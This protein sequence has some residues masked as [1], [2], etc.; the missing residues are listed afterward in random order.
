[1]KYLKLQYCMIIKKEAYIASHQ[2]GY[3]Y[4][5]CNRINVDKAQ[6]E[7]LIWTCFFI[8]KYFRKT[9]SFFQAVI[10]VLKESFRCENGCTKLIRKQLLH[11]E[12]RHLV[13][14]NRNKM[15]ALNCVWRRMR[16]RSTSFVFEVHRL[17][18]FVLTTK[19]FHD[20]PSYS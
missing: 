18:S 19:Y 16:L 2:K 9:L 1:M 5:Y 10:N 15:A 11:K 17:R 20:F 12:R 6:A 8:Q 7:S 3:F 13:D 14:V 4:M